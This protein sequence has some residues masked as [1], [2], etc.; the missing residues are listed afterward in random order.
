MF[1]REYLCVSLINVY[2]FRV[3]KDHLV[4]LAEME[5]KVQLA[6]QAP[7]VPRDH[8]E[9]MVTRLDHLISV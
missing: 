5:F 3:R 4:L 8:L 1:V 6:Y 7:L 9:R 2:L